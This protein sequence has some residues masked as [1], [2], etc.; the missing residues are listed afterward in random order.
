[1]TDQIEPRVIPV[2][3]EEE[4]KT[5]FLDYSMSFIL[6]RALHDVRDGLK[7]SQRRIV[8]AMNDQSLAPNRGYRKCAKIAGDT[9]GNYHPHG[10]AIVYPTLC[11]WRR[12]SACAVR[13]C[14]GRVI[15]ARST[16]TRRR[17]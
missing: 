11:I 14:R 7:P 8:V 6:S 17:R 5:S 4:L 9:S 16:V 3:I 12:I 15:L 1:M 2:K 13:S 10:E